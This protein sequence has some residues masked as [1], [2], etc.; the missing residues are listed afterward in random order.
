M[1]T[2]QQNSGNQD[3]PFSPGMPDLL[4]AAAARLSNELEHRPDQLPL[5]QHA[6]QATWHSAMKRWSH[7]VTRLEELEITRDD[8][9]GYHGDDE[10]PDLGECLNLR[11]DDACAE[12]AER[13]AASAARRRDEGDGRGGAQ[14][15]VPGPGAP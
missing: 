13:F 6:L 5:L 12:A 2:P 1:A 7:G 3:A 14:S 10:V 15:D 4:L 9:P 11:A 8:L